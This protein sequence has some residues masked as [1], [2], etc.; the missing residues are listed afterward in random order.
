MINIL[1]IHGLGSSDQSN[2][3]RL[4]HSL[5]DNEMTFYNPSFSL[6]PKKAME[7]INQF[8]KDK[9]I[10][11]VIGSSLGGFYA[12]ES[13]CPF[14]VVINPALTP[15]DDL[16]KSIGLG[17]HKYVHS[18]DTYII[19]DSF[20]NELEWIIRRHYKEKDI[21]RWFVS[22]KDSKYFGGIFGNKDELFSHYDD[23]HL[24][25]SSLVILLG[26]MGHR[27]DPKYLPILMDFLN[28][29]IKTKNKTITKNNNN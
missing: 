2:T 12:L 3:G 27:F 5:S 25:N 22:L 21:N 28:E 11:V 18:D 9:H 7:E 16:K 19:D 24:I 13:D 4:L 14:G 23:F 6:S 20:L 26:D 1:Y 29:I 17:E 15:I 10:D 8:I